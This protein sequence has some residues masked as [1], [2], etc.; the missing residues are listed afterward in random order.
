L[1]VRDGA[2]QARAQGVRLAVASRR[3]RLQAM[4]IATLIA[5]RDL[6]DPRTLIRRRQRRLR[7]SFRQEVQLRVDV[8][9][10]IEQLG[11]YLRK[12]AAF[13]EHCRQQSPT[14]LAADRRSRPRQR[15]DRGR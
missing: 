10:G 5:V 13:E 7:L 2:Q 6:L 11:E 4:L 12:Y 9:P 3:R 1:T 14:P 15:P 8:R